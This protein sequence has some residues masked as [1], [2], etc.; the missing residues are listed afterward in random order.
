MFQWYTIVV[1]QD[2]IKASGFK[3]IAATVTGSTDFRI[4]PA[5]QH[6]SIS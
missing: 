5:E 6:H 1:L 2:D 4:L 3:S